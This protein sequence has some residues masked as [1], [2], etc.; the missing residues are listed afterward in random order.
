MRLNKDLEY[1]DLDGCKIWTGVNIC[2][3]NELLTTLIESFIPKLYSKYVE[4]NERY[5]DG[6]KNY[7]PGVPE[8][9]RK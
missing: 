1:D 2:S 9:S 8:L 3:L 6:C 5:S 4:L 7:A